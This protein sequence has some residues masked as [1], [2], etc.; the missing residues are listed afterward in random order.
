[1]KRFLLVTNNEKEKN[2]RMAEE[3]I[4]AIESRGGSATWE[5]M[6][7]RSDRS[8]IPVAEDVECIL[9]IGGDGTMVRTAQ[10]TQGS[11]VPLLGLNL[12]H[13]GY[14]CDLSRDNYK[15]ALDLLLKDQYKTE[16]RMMLSGKFQ[17]AAKEE[18]FV[19]LNDVVLTVGDGFSVIHL[20]IYVNGIRLYSF[21]GDGLIIS[22]PTGSTAYNLSAHGPIVEPKTELIL[23]SPINPHTLNTR[24]IVLDS[25][26][27]V[28]VEIQP[29]RSGKSEVVNVTFDGARRSLLH[30]DE[31]L[32]VKRADNPVHFVLLD[33][34]SFLERMQEKLQT[35]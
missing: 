29:R 5:V 13:L 2:V 8:P 19:S 25:K 14:L 1:M 3:V 7:P 17:P 20:V 31:Q 12:G 24:S 27:E 21:V 30:V 23:L 35:N 9:T 6:P 28:T 11:M 33:E 15:Q 32:I 18:P 10:R 4:E 22:T 34:K 26:D 16:P